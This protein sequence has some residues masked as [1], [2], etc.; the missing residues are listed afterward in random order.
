MWD[1]PA[2]QMGPA[3]LGVQVLAVFP[4]VVDQPLKQQAHR[5]LPGQY[6]AVQMSEGN[7]CEDVARR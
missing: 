4:V 6:P 5:S 7:V 1:T 2:G 3:G